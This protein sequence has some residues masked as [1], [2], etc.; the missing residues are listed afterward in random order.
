M[1]EIENSKFPGVFRVQ[2]GKRSSLATRT[3]VPDQS[4]YGEKLVSID[5]EEFRLWATRR[6]KLAAAIHNGLNE[7]P[8]QLGSRVLYLGAASGTTVSHVSDIIGPEGAVYGVEF[9]PRTARDLFTLATTRTNI[10]PIVDDARYPSRYNPIVTGPI[11]VSGCCTIK[12][13]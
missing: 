2:D 13:V 7:M 1:N 10:Y 9:S 5:N 8:I 3:L 4:V 11:D 6:S 12:P